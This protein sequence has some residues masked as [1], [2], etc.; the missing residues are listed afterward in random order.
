MQDATHFIVHPEYVILSNDKR[1]KLQFRDRIQELVR[2]H[3]CYL[4]Q[5]EVSPN[6]ET[7]SDRDLLLSLYGRVLVPERNIL[8]SN[9]VTSRFNDV[10]VFGHV[11]HNDFFRLPKIIANGKPIRVHGCFYGDACIQNLALQLYGLMKTGRNWYDWS[12]LSVRGF[13]AEK[14]ISVALEMTGFADTPL[15]KY[16]VVY[17]ND[18]VGRKTSLSFFSR[19]FAKR[20]LDEQLSDSKTEVFGMIK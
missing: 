6:P 8:E 10:N 19:L 13:V 16:G 12:K 4:V 2:D 17:S 18:H 7:G 15:V 20:T 5:S 9:T 11:T 1:S 14:M 3:E